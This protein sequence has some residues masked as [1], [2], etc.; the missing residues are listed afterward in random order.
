L[1]CYVRTGANAYCNGSDIDKK[2]QVNL[3]DYALLANNWGESLFIKACGGIDNP[4]PVGDL[5]HNCMVDIF[6]IE[7]LAAE[8]LNDCN[9]LNYN[10]RE[11]DLHRDGVTNLIDYSVLSGNL[12]N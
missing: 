4:R 12:T 1:K 6:D 8:W 9:W 10:C 5:D 3:T 7:I 11:A 2:G